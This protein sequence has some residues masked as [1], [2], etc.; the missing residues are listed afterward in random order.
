MARPNFNV[1]KAMGGSDSENTFESA[2]KIRGLF[3][4]EI[5][6]SSAFDVKKPNKED[7]KKIEISKLIPSPRNPFKVITDNEDMEKLMASISEKGIMDPLWVRPRG[8]GTYEILSGHRRRYAA[9]QLGIEELPALV[10]E[11]VSEE[12][13]DIIMV[14]ANLK[15]ESVLPSEK[16]LS[17][18]LKYNAIKKSR[19][20][21][22]TG[23]SEGNTAEAIGELMGISGRQLLTYVTVAQLRP[24]LLDLL[25]NKKF[26][27]ETATKLASLSG[28]TQ[29]ELAKYIVAGGVKV[30]KA[31]A[32]TL[33]TT[34]KEADITADEIADILET[35]KA[36]RGR[37]AKTNVKLS[38]EWKEKY[39]PGGEKDAEIEKTIMELLEN[40]L[41]GERK[42]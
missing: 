19:G 40:R 41:A 3:G 37:K 31:K 39:F 8:D 24:E 35:Q 4:E 9:E 16:A 29:D 21:N 42:N 10:Y 13:A 1:R 15:R 2:G 14:D 32:K 20:G 34:V 12:D 27:L 38:S 11:D 23:E 26:T 7:I 5:A 25:D 6:D 36:K 18:S 30:D 17:A 22:R 28:F 33:V